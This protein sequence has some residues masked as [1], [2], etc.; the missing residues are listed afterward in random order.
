[1]SS[2]EIKLVTR[3][4]NLPGLNLHG[5]NLPGLNLPDL[6][7]PV[8]QLA[9]VH[10]AGVHFAGFHLFRDSLVRAS[11]TQIHYRTDK[12]QVY[13]YIHHNFQRCKDFHAEM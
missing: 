9:G 1:M 12:N 13:R 11:G 2:V 8:V 10:L 7:L 5:L 3:C 4:L 6:N